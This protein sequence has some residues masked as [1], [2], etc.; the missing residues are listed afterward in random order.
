MNRIELGRWGEEA[1]AHYLLKKRYLIV[2]R[3]VSF[4]HGEIDLIMLDGETL[5]FVEVKTRRQLTYGT[6]AEA[7]NRKKQQKLRELAITYLQQQDKFYSNFR[8]DVCAVLYSS[9]KPVVIQHIPH[10]F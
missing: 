2:Q 10:A 4:K 8:F 3:N 1:A 6:P 9:D 7:V 5:V